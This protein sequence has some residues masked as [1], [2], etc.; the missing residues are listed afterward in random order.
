MKTSLITSLAALALGVGAQA[1]TMIEVR[2]ET[3]GPVGLAPA[4]AG[5]SNGSFDI[6]DTGS[7]ASGALED[8]AETGSPAGFSPTNGGPVFGPGVG[9]GS[10]PIFGPSGAMASTIFSVDDG[11]GMFNIASMVLPSNDWFIGNA[12]AFDV[13]SLLGASS[14]TSLSFDLSNVYD[15]GTELEDFDFSPGNGLIG[16][17]NPGGGAA[18]FGTDQN[19]VISLV[20]GPDPFG[21][22]ANIAPGGFDTTAA[23]FTGG[24]VAR[25]TLTVVPEP[26]AA[27][28]GFIGAIAI[29]G[30]RSRR[31]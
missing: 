19:G 15:A 29:A 10:P 26:S 12:D 2:V 30:R 4:I 23:D 8:L 18:D 31:N 25:V 27:A 17:T 3:L 9:P 24:P 14:G 21:S 13:S 7:V 22:F 1:A 11:N 28:L 20:T 5:F 6:F 16:I